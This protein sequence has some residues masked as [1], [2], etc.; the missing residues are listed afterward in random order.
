[1]DFLLEPLE[2]GTEFDNL[3]SETSIKVSCARGYAC[4]RGEVE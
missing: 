2:L 3:V 1:M 4:D